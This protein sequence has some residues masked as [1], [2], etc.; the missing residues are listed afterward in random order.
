MSFQWNSLFGA[1]G[2]H[3]HIGESGGAADHIGIVGIERVQ[4]VEAVRGGAGDAER[5]DQDHV[6]AQLAP[7]ASGDGIGLALEVQHEGRAGVFEQVG[8]DG[9]DAFAGAGR[10]AGQHMAVL[11]EPAIGAARCVAHDAQHEGICGRGRRQMT[12][13]VPR[14]PEMG[15]PVGMKRLAREQGCPQAPD[16]TR[17][18]PPPAIRT[19]MTSRPRAENQPLWAESRSAARTGEKHPG[20]R[21]PQDNPRPP[22]RV[23]FSPNRFDARQKPMAANTSTIAADDHD[24]SFKWINRRRRATAAWADRPPARTTRAGQPQTRTRHAASALVPRE[25]AGA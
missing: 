9:A 24:E 10:G 18:Q 23:R 7:G 25:R 2:D 1:L 20:E 11:A 13:R 17:N 8:D 3:Q 14:R 4:P 5:I 6:V 22:S 12:R 21:N 16:R 19:T 15:G